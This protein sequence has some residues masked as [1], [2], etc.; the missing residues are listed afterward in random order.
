[1]YIKLI[2]L[3]P[4]GISCEQRQRQTITKN[5]NKDSQHILANEQKHFKYVQHRFDV[6]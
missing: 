4:Y 5:N 6:I 2:S 3:S 1:M